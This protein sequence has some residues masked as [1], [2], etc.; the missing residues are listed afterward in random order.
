MDTA[1]SVA[2]VVLTVLGALV[3]V[4]TGLAGGLRLIAPKT[5]TTVDD[6]AVS[7]LDRA[8]A[9]IRWIDEKL[10]ALLGMVTRAKVER[11]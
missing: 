5:D 6:R 2:S 9:V 7:F 4:L 11:Q 10:L 3:V 1:I 8:V